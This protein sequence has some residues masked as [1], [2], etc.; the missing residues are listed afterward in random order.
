MRCRDVPRLASPFE[1][2]I[3]VSVLFMLRPQEGS[4]PL[5]VICVGQRQ[6]AEGYF[7]LQH[8][9]GAH[10]SENI[11]HAPAALCRLPM[12]T[13]LLNDVEAFKTNSVW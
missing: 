4:S 9:S 2:V 5:S 1:E 6:R 12:V 3:K 8:S 10:Y 7:Y 11:T 13:E